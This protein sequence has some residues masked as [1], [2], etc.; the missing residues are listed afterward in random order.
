[1][2]CKTTVLGSVLIALVSGMTIIPLVKGWATLCAYATGGAPIGMLYSFALPI[3]CL[4]WAAGRASG[5][6]LCE[7]EDEM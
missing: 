7:D 5:F 1:M 3:L 2:K 6:K 4:L